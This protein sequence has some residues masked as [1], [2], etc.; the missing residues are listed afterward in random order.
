M[1]A[2]SVCYIVCSLYISVMLPYGEL[3]LLYIISYIQTGVWLAAKEMD[4]S[5][6]LCA[7]CLRK[8][9]TLRYIYA[10]TAYDNA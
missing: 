4:I 2:I 5:T 6:V 3:R 1:F 10:R 8:D 9:S 7:L